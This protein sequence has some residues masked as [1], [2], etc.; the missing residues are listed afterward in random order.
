MST[1]LNAARIGRSTT[2]SANAGSPGRKR[3]SNGLTQL[4]ERELVAELNQHAA[5]ERARPKM[6][7]TCERCQALLEQR[8]HRI[9]AIE[10]ADREPRS[11]SSGQVHR[12]DS[13]SS[14][15]YSI[16]GV[17]PH[18][19]SRLLVSEQHRCAIPQGNDGVPA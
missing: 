4:F 3:R 1:L 14:S 8:F 5:S 16:V 13:S 7:H 10:T 18:S 17:Y 19:Q 12:C 2:G 6:M 11:P 9:G 15:G